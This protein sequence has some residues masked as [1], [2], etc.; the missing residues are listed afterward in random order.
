MQVTL[1]QPLIIKKRHLLKLFL[2]PY[3]FLL[4]EPLI[5]DDTSIS[6]QTTTDTPANEFSP[7]KYVM[8]IKSARSQICRSI[9][10]SKNHRPEKKHLGSLLPN[11]KL[12]FRQEFQSTTS[13]FLFGV[14]K[15]KR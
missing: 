7:T 6:W 1:K 15:T 2:S 9:E 5:D 11:L 13:I 12:K 14:H 10:I 8:Q 4:F 3:L